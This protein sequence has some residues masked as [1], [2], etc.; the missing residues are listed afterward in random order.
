M[1]I[2]WT[3]PLG[4][5]GIK[6]VAENMQR[7]D[8]SS[9]TQLPVGWPKRQDHLLGGLETWRDMVSIII[10]TTVAKQLKAGADIK[11]TATRESVCISFGKFFI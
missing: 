11:S 5:I 10:Q 4:V 7:V 3:S 8:F 1:L 6:L 2:T 9:K